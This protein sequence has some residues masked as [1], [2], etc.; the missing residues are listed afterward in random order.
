MDFPDLAPHLLADEAVIGVAL[1]HGAELDHVQR[2]AQVHLHDDKFT[3]PRNSL[4]L[5][6][7]AKRGIRRRPFC[8]YISKSESRVKS[9]V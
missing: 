4:P 1:R 8:R 2:F 5:S 6:H 7:G 9:V 3:E